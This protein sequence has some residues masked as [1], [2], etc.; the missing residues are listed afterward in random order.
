MGD[1]RKS[2]NRKLVIEQQAE[3]LLSSYLQIPNLASLMKNW[4][5]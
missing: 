5:L 3:F 1:M 4:N 2:A